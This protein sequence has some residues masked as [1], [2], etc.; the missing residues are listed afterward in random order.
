M[1]CQLKINILITVFSTVNV[2]LCA[3]LPNIC[4]KH[5]QFSS[6]LVKAKPSV[7]GTHEIIRA[8]AVGLL[9]LAF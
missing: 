1:P 3:I 6:S 7:N 5:G 4:E 8:G 9:A 2:D